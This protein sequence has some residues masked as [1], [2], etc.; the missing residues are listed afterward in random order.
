LSFEFNAINVVDITLCDPTCS[1]ETSIDF[2]RS[3]RRYIAIGRTPHNHLSEDPK[4]QS[5]IRCSK[6]R[7]VFFVHVPFP[8]RTI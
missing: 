4:S 5:E 7:V 3:K 6:Q 8:N 1:S 2:Q